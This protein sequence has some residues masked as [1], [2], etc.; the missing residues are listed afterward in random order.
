MTW[1][2]TGGAGYIGAHV[3]RALHEAGEHVVVLDDLS[4]G[5]LDRVPAGVPLVVASVLDGRRVAQTL[6]EYAVDGVIHLAGKKAV[7][8]SV[9]FP[10]RYYH[11]NSE[12]VR[13][14]LQAMADCGTRRLV[15][16]SSAAV[17]GVPTAA[18]VGE[19]A[20]AT[21]QSPYGR[22]K[23]VGEWMV[24]DAAR[25]QGVGAVSLRYFNVVGCATPE[26]ADRAGSNLFPRVLDALRDGRR[27]TVF[28]SDYPTSDGS[29]VRDYIHVAD[30]AEAHVAATRL[31]DRLSDPSPDRGGHQVLNVGCGRGYSV[32]EV[33]RAFAEITGLDTTPL[34]LPRRPGD[35]G[36]VVADPSRAAA[37]LGWSARHDLTD[38]VTSAWE[39]E[40]VER[41]A[42]A[43]AT[44][45]S[46]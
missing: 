27:P 17:Y 43:A 10:L 32:L 36:S 7:E 11:E 39:A 21:P 22:S 38:M 34:I 25:S 30:L 12:G 44:Q 45:T 14:L 9:R 29:G 42:L 20:P 37:V 18:L 16:S 46:A 26:L 5:D 23:L 15:F 24:A 4:T 8:E 19:D 31:A 35:A 13:T 40:Q 28:G 3:L 6:R 1:M 33:L 2:L 41:A